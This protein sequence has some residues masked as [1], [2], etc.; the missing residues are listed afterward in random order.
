MINEKL[1]EINSEATIQLHRQSTA[2]LATATKSHD[3]IKGSELQ[4]VTLID[5]TKELETRNQM[6]A[7]QSNARLVELRRQNSNLIEQIANL[8]AENEKFAD[9]HR[10]EYPSWTLSLRLRTQAYNLPLVR[11]HQADKQKLE[12][13][14]KALK[15]SDISLDAKLS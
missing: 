14:K 6:T 7:Q 11:N 12:K 1:A 9:E 2:I 10:R 4:N 8:T 5:R 13:I 15:V 3:R